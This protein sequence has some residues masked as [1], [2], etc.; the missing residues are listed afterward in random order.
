MMMRVTLSLQQGGSGNWGVRCLF[1]VDRQNQQEWRIQRYLAFSAK[2]IDT[3]QG[4]VCS[5]YPED[6]DDP[7]ALAADVYGQLVWQGCRL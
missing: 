7:M 6:G 4:F 5:R 1:L 2:K 3:K